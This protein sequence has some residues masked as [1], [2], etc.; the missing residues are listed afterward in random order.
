M[1]PSPACRFQCSWQSSLVRKRSRPVDQLVESLYFFNTRNRVYF[2]LIT[3]V[4]NIPRWVFWLCIWR[5][6]FNQTRCCWMCNRL[7]VSFWING[8][9]FTLIHNLFVLTRDSI[10]SGLIGFIYFSQ[11]CIALFCLLTLVIGTRTSIVGTNWGTCNICGWTSKLSTVT[12]TT[13][14][15]KVF[16]IS[17]MQLLALGNVSIPNRSLSQSFLWWS[18]RLMF[19]D[20]IRGES[21]TVLLISSHL[22]IVLRGFRSFGS[23][24]I[25]C[26]LW[27]SSCVG[28]I[29]SCTRVHV[30]HRL[31]LIRTFSF[32]C[33][34]KKHPRT[35]QK[36]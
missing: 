18:T 9:F 4:H 17:T 12:V 5:R 1:Y 23:I 7:R 36:E 6:V 10:G 28:G 34:F 33:S 35:S 8:S 13:S 30:G 11:H 16:A 2:W 3:Y 22:K 14:C 21:I 25:R 29:V 15:S 26:I 32:F 19:T 27:G 20:S 31:L 24:S